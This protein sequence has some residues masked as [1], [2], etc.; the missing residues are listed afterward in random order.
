M[1]RTGGFRSHPT[2]YLET[3]AD[4]QIR[5]GSTG[6][7]EAAPTGFTSGLAGLE[8]PHEQGKLFSSESPAASAGRTN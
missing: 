3:P 5:E 1:R 8:S 2:A 6:G 7:G 4:P